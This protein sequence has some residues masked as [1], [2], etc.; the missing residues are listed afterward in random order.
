MPGAGRR[1]SGSACSS[2]PTGPTTWTWSSAH[3]R[4]AEPGVVLAAVDRYVA[5]GH[6]AFRSTRMSEVADAPRR[7]PQV[8][9]GER[10]PLSG[11]LSAPD[12]PPLVRGR[13]GSRSPSADIFV[14]HPLLALE[15]PCL[16]PP[17]LVT[18][19]S[20]RST[21]SRI[22]PWRPVVALAGVTERWHRTGCRSQPDRAA[23]ETTGGGRIAVAEPMH[24]GM[25]S[26]PRMRS[27]GA[28][29]A[30]SAPRE[31]GSP[32]GHPRVPGRRDGGPHHRARRA[33]LGTRGP[34][35]RIAVGVLAAIGRLPSLPGLPVRGR[36]RAGPGP[37]AGPGEYAAPGGRV[38]RRH[39]AG[40]VHGR[41]DRASDARHRS[42]LAANGIPAT[43]LDAYRRAAAGSPYACHIGW[44]LIAAIGRV[45]SNHGRFRGAALDDAGRSS[46]PI[47]GIPLNGVGTALIRDTDGGTLDNDTAF[48]RAVGPMQFIP[49]TW[50]RYAADGNGDGRDEPVQHLRR[51]PGGSELSLCGRRRPVHRRRKDPRGAGL[52]PQRELRSDGSGARGHLRRRC[53]ADAARPGPRRAAVRAAGRSRDPTCP[54]Q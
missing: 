26:P 30:Q 42:P 13:P 23:S 6:A 49:S 52:Q 43:A 2:P 31:R 4:A 18:V 28:A 40:R 15:S 50:R 51:G 7:L 34:C 38:A 5:A 27:P 36:R 46:P 12:G 54:C 10:N 21:R 22:L 45:E 39:G 1:S 24:P 9:V 37:R 19:V 8:A 16:G 33:A 14:I 35:R 11:T 29:E 32:S 48:D 47:V 17:P 53:R 20:S 3:R 25:A 44:S 41:G